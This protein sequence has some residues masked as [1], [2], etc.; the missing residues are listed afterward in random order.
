MNV[1]YNYYFHI[2]LQFQ[3]KYFLFYYSLLPQHVSAPTG[4]PQV[5][6]NINLSFYGA[7]NATT[8]PSFRDCPYKKVIVAQLLI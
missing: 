2:C 8:D 3:L 5:E 1:L 6:H 4:H 7:I